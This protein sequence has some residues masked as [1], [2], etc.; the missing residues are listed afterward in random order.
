MEEYVVLVNERDEALGVA[1][2]LRV[3]REGTLHR[4]FSVFVFNTEGSLL[5]Q[6]RHPAKYHSGGLWSNTCCSHPRPG[7]AVAAAARRRLQEEMGFDCE[8]RRVFGF[9]YRVRFDGDLS[10]HEY[11]HVFV[12]LF[13]GS[14]V[15]DAA[16]VAAWRWVR[17]EALRRDVARRPD[18]YT[19]WF[20]LALDRVLACRPGGAPSEARP[21]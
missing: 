10:E 17:P 11:D 16:E 14:P 6:Q 8:L 18:R 4:A 21:A 13:D 15:P 3:H 7:E 12:G 1:E 9:V 2:K 19:Y 5:L 20:R